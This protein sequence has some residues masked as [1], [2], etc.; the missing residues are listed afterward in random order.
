[1]KIQN[2]GPIKYLEIDLNKMNVFVGENETGKTIAAYAIF[3]FVYWFNTNFFA[4]ILSEKDIKDVLYKKKIS[5]SIED[6]KDKI[7]NRAIEI[8]NSFNFEVFDSFFNHT[9]IYTENS[10][11]KITKS[12]VEAL[13]IDP[14]FT[15]RWYYDWNFRKRT[16]DFANNFV[17]SIGPDSENVNRIVC[18]KNKDKIDIEYFPAKGVSQNNLQDQFDELKNNTEGKG[19]MT[20]NISVQ[21]I[22]FKSFPGMRPVYLPAERIG[23]NVFRPY[24]NLNRL[25]KVTPES[26]LN[27]RQNQEG[28]SRYVFPIENYIRFVN[29]NAENLNKV[30]DSVDNNNLIKELIPGKFIYDKETDSVRYNLVDSSQLIMDFEVISSSLKSIFG[31]DLFFKS[32]PEGRWLFFDE[33]EMNLHPEKQKNVANLTYNLMKKGIRLVVSTHSDYYVKQ[34]INCVLKD[35]LNGQE[36]SEINVYEFKDGMATKLNN[37]FNIDE[38]VNNFDNTTREINN[39]YYDIIDKLETEDESNE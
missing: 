8:F 3:A 22:I 15:S 24:L 35:K 37:I 33:P 20:I 38:P 34:L 1:M 25:N 6:A 14:K 36:N 39:E 4:E 32:K 7:I 30:D 13:V 9:G 12:D 28:F 11:I 18:T 19:F 31:L 17:E 27:E 23:I 2:L 10:K 29:N 21:N 5:I 26:P 16:P